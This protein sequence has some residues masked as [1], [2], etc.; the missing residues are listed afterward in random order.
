MQEVNLGLKELGD[1]VATRRGSEDEH[2]GDV[3]EGLG[4]IRVVTALSVYL[5][6]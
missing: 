1:T 5:S 6:H 4:Q 2:G 3:G